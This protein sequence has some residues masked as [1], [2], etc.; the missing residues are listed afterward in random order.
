MRMT[1]QKEAPMEFSFSPEQELI[2]KA[3]REFAETVI[4]PRVAEFERTHE[5]PVDIFHAMGEQGFL[6]IT[7]PPEYGGT[8]LG[9]L[10]RMLAIEEMARISPAMGFMLQ[11]FALGAAPIL[12]FGTPEQKARYLPALARG[13]YFSTVSVT[14]ATGGSNPFGITTTAEREGDHYI[15]NGR[16][17]FITGSSLCH[18]HTVS[19]ITGQDER[20]RK[21]ISAFLLT[22]DMPG[23]KVG[24]E[25]HKVGLLGTQLGEF[26]LVNCE[27]PAESMLSKP[28]DGIKVAMKSISETGRPG[29]AATALGI[30]ARALQESVKFA[31]ERVVGGCPIAEHQ[32]IQF[33]IADMSIA[34]DTARLI[35][36]RGAWMKDQGV[37]C[38]VETSKAKLYATE[39]AMV[40][41]RH[42]GEIHGGYGWL[43]EYVAQQ[44]YRDAAILIPSAGTS[45]MMRVVAGR[46]ALKG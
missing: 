21:I 33:K 44:L 2:R 41:A 46:A 15:L 31:N 28:G 3:A 36:Y 20:G 10:A 5:S 35:C 39:A 16:K 14:E 13:D 42:C 18:L 27:A 32:G 1:T 19:A 6:G 38:D 45:E 11:V 9:H 24:R 12:D 34:L 17:V 25:E 7:I 26:A 8:G 40:A 30:I 4:A 22:Q 43:Q 29:I 37:R 23:F